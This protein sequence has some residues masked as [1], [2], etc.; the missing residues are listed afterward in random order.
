MI[1]LPGDLSAR[2]D[3]ETVYTNN[4]GRK[5]RITSD[6]K[7]SQEETD[8]CDDSEGT[9]RKYVRARGVVREG[10]GLIRVSIVN[11]DVTIRR[12]RW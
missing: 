3:L 12:G 2:S 4:L 1:E 8:R 5:R 9:P 7:L 10:G 11:G 6:C